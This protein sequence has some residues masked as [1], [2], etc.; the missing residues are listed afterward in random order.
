MLGNDFT[1]QIFLLPGFGTT[2]VDNA[3]WDVCLPDITQLYGI[4][5]TFWRQMQQLCM[6][7]VSPISLWSTS[8]QQVIKCHCDATMNCSYIGSGC[9]FWQ[10][11][12]Y[13]LRE[14][15]KQ[16]HPLWLANWWGYPIWK[17]KSINSVEIFVINILCCV[18][19]TTFVNTAGC[20][21]RWGASEISW[22]L[23]AWLGCLGWLAIHHCHSAW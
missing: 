21:L 23:I 16:W 18:N 22:R 3:L 13:S 10:L 7:T 9:W 5:R 11:S 1:L 20:W 15:I 2:I 17:R 12:C 14:L 8:Y 4:Y 6:L 19:L